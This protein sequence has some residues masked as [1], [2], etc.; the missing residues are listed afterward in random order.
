[1][2]FRVSLG[3]TLI[4]LGAGAMSA[5]AATVTLPR[6]GQVGIAVQGGYGSLIDA[7]GIGGEFGDGPTFAIRLRYRM[8]YERGIGLSF[9]TSKFASRLARPFDPDNAELTTFPDELKVV[10]SGLDYYQFFGTRTPTVKLISIGAGLAQQRVALN[11]GE[12]ELSGE[13]SGD[14]LYL[15]GGFGIERFFYKSFALDLSGRYYAM[16][17]DGKVGHNVQFGIGVIGY[18]G[19]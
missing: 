6:P 11:S 5:G 4:V 18:A 9:E 1:M 8:R 10:L 15:S 14:G 19:Y 2:R 17:R 16:F 3:I 12:T 7:G 13:F